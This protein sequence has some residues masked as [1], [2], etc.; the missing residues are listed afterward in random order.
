MTKELLWKIE[1]LWNQYYKKSSTKSPILSQSS[2]FIKRGVFNPQ[3][4]RECVFEDAY[5][6]YYGLKESFFIK[7][8]PPVYIFDNH[9]KA[10]FPFLEYKNCIKRPISIVHIDAHPDDA[11]VSEKNIPKIDKEN[12]EK[13]YLGT[14]ISDFLDCGERG[15]LIKNIQRVTQEKDFL[16]NPKPPSQYTLSLDIDIFGPEGAFTSLESKIATIAYYWNKADIITI[17][18][19]PGFIDQ[20]FAYKIIKILLNQK[21]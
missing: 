12:I 6:E 9:N 3:K 13:V 15:N 10:L 8:S 21:V 20:Q 16:H 17:A 5:G 1:S 2:Y 19:S 7:T 11:L 18:T 14:K 4:S